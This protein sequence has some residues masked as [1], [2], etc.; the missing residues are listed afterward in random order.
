MNK[1]FDPAIDSYKSAVK[2]L[3][4]KIGKVERMGS[5]LSA[6]MDTIQCGSPCMQTY[7]DSV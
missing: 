2:C 3:E 7:S 5:E 4:D 6:C 1:Q